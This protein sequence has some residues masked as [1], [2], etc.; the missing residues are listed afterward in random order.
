M[1]IAH[2]VALINEV[3]V[4]IKM[5]DVDRPT[6]FER[7]DHRGVDR[8]ITAQDHGHGTCRENL[9][10]GRLDVGVAGGHVGM[11]DIGIADIN[12]AQLVIG[13]VGGVI[14]K[15]VGAGMAEGEQRRCLADAAR[16]KTCA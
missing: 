3:Q 16:S 12:H 7:L 5:H 14:F 15:I 11:D 4:G 13:Q 9:A 2:A 8:V 1:A 6:S 10:H